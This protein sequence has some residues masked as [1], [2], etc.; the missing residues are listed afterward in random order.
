MNESVAIIVTAAARGRA[1]PAVGTVDV[2]I[3]AEA[4]PA[5]V[6]IYSRCCTVPISRAV[7]VAI[8]PSPILLLLHNF[9]SNFAW[10]P[11]FTN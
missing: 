11:L 6:V 8:V 9:S 3:A 4:P 2:A 7:A 1:S 10:R 5:V